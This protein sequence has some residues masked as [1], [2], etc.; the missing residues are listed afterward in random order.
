MANKTKKAYQDSCKE[1]TEHQEITLTALD[2]T[3]I[4]S[5]KD[6]IHAFRDNEEIFVGPFRNAKSIYGESIP[7]L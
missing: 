2:A 3:S 5:C 1:A 4:T 6:V 7:K